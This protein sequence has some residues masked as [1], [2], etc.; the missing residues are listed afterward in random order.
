MARLQPIAPCYLRLASATAAQRAAFGEQFRPGGAVDGAV[1]AA[2]SEQ[3]RV[4][5]I[6][7]GVNVEGRDVGDDYLDAIRHCSS[8]GIRLPDRLQVCSCC[9]LKSD[10]GTGAQGNAI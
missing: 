5:G 10:P 3:G 4:G 2:A 8:Q 1:H 6:D 9:Y 7:E